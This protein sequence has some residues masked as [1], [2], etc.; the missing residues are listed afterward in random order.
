MTVNDAKAV[1][2]RL[3]ERI[4]NLPLPVGLGIA[5]ILAA[6]LLLALIG[7]SGPPYQ[8]LYEGLTPQQG[9]EVIAQLQKLG[10]PYQL[11]RAGAIIAVP[12]ADMGRARLELASSGAPA[13]DASNAWKNLENVPMTASEASIQALQLEAAQSSLEESIKQ[14]SGAREVQVMIASPPDTPF[15]ATQP[16]PKVSVVMIGAPEPDEALGMTV[17]RVVAGAVP[18]VAMQDVVVATSG[19]KILYPASST[20]DASRQLA[21]QQSVEAAQ[22]AKIRSLLTPVVGAENFRTAISADVEF[23]RATITSI[24]Y[25]PH[26]YPI[27]LDV[28]QTRRTGNQTLPI[29]IPGALSNQPPGPTTAPLNPPAAAPPAGTAA[30]GQPVAPGTSQTATTSGGQPLPVSTSNHSQ[31]RYAIDQTSTEAHPASWHVKA[32]SI[33][34]VINRAALGP[35]TPEQ[36]KTLI[37]ATTTMPLSAVAVIPARFIASKASPK[38]QVGSVLPNILRA[39]FLLIA[40]I[41]VLTGFLLPL[42]A[43][44]ADLTGRPSRLFLEPVKPQEED[45]QTEARALLG[46]TVDKVRLTVQSEPLIV[47]RTLQK[48]LEQ[49]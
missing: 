39:T 48:W 17:A 28:E 45:A 47:V 25:G 1:G 49:A 15:L 31:T 2:Q 10:I 20:Y 38:G 19:G 23:G 16:E 37:S 44:L 22:E 43:W 32:I 9:G 30:N 4:R 35:I 33:S 12:V 13:E 29:G 3:L 18:S 34:V 27:S 42:R 40:A 36:L 21:I 46:Q 7:M 24:T 14:V 11:D 6:L 5:A 8:V 26:S 41:A